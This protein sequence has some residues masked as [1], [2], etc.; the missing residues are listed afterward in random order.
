MHKSDADYIKFEIGQ[1]AIFLRSV[2]NK[3]FNS[4]EELAKLLGVHRQMVFFYLSGKCKL[5]NSSFQKLVNISNINPN[6]FTFEIVPYSIY[7]K[8]T[9]PN[10]VTPT[11]AEFLGIMLGDG[12]AYS[13][14]HQITISCGDIDGSYI[15]KYIPRIINELFSKRVSFRK[16]SRGGLDCIFAS[17]EV[18]NYLDKEMGFKSP[19]VNCQIPTQFF[20]EDKL[21]KACIRGLFDT[22]GGLHKHH[23]KSAQLHFTNKSVPL[24]KSLRN[25]LQQLG[26]VPSNLTLNHKEKDTYVIYLFTQDVKKYF[27]EIGSS[28]PKNQLKFNEW[29]KTGVVPLNKEIQNQVKLS[30]KTQES[31]LNKN[32]DSI[33]YFGFGEKS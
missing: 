23:K 15:S 30:R 14:N 18:C 1:Q 22:D 27:R 19:K 7:G 4:W 16:Q 24:L 26:Y 6:N 9:I 32:L 33:K 11:L 10:K 8:P 3:L 17:K 2:K 12:C 21:L 13:K 28:N 25:A 5:P 20:K 29:I 31:L